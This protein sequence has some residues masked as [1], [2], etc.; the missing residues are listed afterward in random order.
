MLHVSL[1]QWIHTC[2][3]KIY[4]C[5]KQTLFAATLL[6]CYSVPGSAVCLVFVFHIDHSKPCNFLVP[7]ILHEHG[8]VSKV[9]H[10]LFSVILLSYSFLQTRSPLVQQKQLME[11][12]CTYTQAQMERQRESERRARDVV[13]HKHKARE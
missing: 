3:K 8:H 6:L 1:K 13:A 11:K 9:L 2:I 12:E 7:H 4:R 5:T 10:M